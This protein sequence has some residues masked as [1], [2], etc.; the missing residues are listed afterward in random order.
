MRILIERSVESRKQ[1]LGRLY[2]LEENDNV[3]MSLDTLELPDKDNQRNISRIPEGVYTALIHYSNRFGKCLWLQDVEDRTEILVHSGNYY[4]D[5]L[6][7][8]LIMATIDWISQS[9]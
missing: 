5:I 7:C 4:T 2:L 3:V 6:G 9:L 1:T 8:I